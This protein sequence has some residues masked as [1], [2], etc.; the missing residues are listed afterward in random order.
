MKTILFYSALSDMSYF[1]NHSFYSNTKEVLEKA[2][3]N[4]NV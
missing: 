1:S 2:G 4:V 3:Y